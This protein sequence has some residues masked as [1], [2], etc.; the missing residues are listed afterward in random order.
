V[1]EYS[2]ERGESMAAQNDIYEVVDV[3]QNNGEVAINVYFYRV[4]SSH[5]TTDASVVAQA[6]VD[7]VLPDVAD[8]QNT[9]V[10][11]TDVNVR[12]LFDASDTFALPVDVD[13]T[14]TN[15]DEFPIFTAISYRLGTDN[16]A[17]RSGAKRYA[18]L[19][20]EQ[21]ANGT[22]TGSSLLAAMDILAATL[23]DTLVS[24]GVYSLVPVV[25]GRILSSPGVYRLP[26]NQGESVFGN[27]VEAIYDTLVTSQVSRKIGSGS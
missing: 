15:S 5:L 18:G 6:Y 21:V 12:N 9:S 13:G 8:I 2:V 22:I 17:I 27:I 26:E 1:S 3:Q 19:D 24:P 4:G 25:V 16:G 23:I 14:Q 20:E 10:N 7:N 11:H